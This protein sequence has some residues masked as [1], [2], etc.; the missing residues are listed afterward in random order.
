MPSNPAD[1]HMIVTPELVDAQANWIAH[2]HKSNGPASAMLVLLSINGFMKS[3]GAPNTNLRK[4]FLEMLAQTDAAFAT[5][6]ASYKS[7][8]AYREAMLKD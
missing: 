1:K 3:C 5:G 8:E 7:A 6:L 4:A 2:V